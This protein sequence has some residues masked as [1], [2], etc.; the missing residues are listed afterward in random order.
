MRR[1]TWAV[2]CTSLL[3]APMLNAQP[4]EPA[5]AL[6]E[7]AVQQT[8]PEAAPTPKLVTLK[9]DTPLDLIATREIS[10]ANLKQGDLFEL[11][12]NKPVEI[13]GVKVIPFMARA[14]GEITLAAKAGGLGRNGSMTARLLYLSLGDTRIPL[15]GDVTNN[16]GGGGSAPVAVI[17][18]GVVGLFHRGNNGKIKAGDH[19][20]AFIAE[21]VLLDLSTTPPR[22]VETQLVPVTA[23]PVVPP[24]L[25]AGAV[26]AAPAA[27]APNP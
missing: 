20:P 1:F 7:A 27:E 4:T 5:Q 15:Q 17:F 24:P 12:V 16:G 25:P 11:A 14:T 10:T 18:A 22:R 8:V 13:D 26:P 23:E 21:D 3:F 6:P 9:R 2:T 19:V